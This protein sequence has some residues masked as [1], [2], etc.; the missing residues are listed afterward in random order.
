[1]NIYR[2]DLLLSSSEYRSQVNVFIASKVLNPCLKPTC[3][4][5]SIYVEV[6]W[7]TFVVS[8]YEVVHEDN[9]LINIFEFAMGTIEGRCSVTWITHWDFNCAKLYGF[10]I[11]TEITE[12]DT[13]DFIVEINGH[14]TI[15]FSRCVS[16]VGYLAFN[17]I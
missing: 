6:I 12:Q 14:T 13:T 10:G 2:I 15:S 17:F 11:H 5:F 3:L 8:E 16:M 1:M 7:Y 9:K 4:S